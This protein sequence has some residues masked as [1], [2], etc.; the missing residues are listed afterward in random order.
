MDNSITSIWGAKQVDKEDV[1]LGHIVLLQ[2][3]DCLADLVTTP[4]D[5]V[6]QQ[7]LEDEGLMYE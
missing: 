1:L 7:H 3:L 4:H 5:V 6:E 2:H